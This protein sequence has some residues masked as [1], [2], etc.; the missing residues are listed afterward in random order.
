MPVHQVADKIGGQLRRGVA[1]DLGHDVDWLDAQAAD[2]VGL[3]VIAT[4][5]CTPQCG[6]GVDPALND[7][8]LLCGVRDEPRGDADLAQLLHP[9]SRRA[10]I[11]PIVPWPR[12]DTGVGS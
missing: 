6:G 3:E 4:V 10:P 11:V 12:K 5:A 7:A 1:D 2:G 9:G 8:E